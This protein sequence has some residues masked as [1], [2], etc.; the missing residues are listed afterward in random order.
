MLQLFEEFDLKIRCFILRFQKLLFWKIREN[1]QEITRGGVFLI[2]ENKI[3]LLPG[4]FL[5]NFQNSYSNIFGWLLLWIMKC[6]KDI[7]VHCF[8]LESFKGRIHC[9]IFLSRH[10]M[11]Y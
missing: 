8:T 10:F 9:E 1:S 4:N 6:P 5:K 2:A 7:S 3:I 11:K